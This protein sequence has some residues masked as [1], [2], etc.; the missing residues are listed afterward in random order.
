MARALQCTDFHV[1]EWLS[2]AARPLP[3]RFAEILMNCQPQT[4]SSRRVPVSIRQTLRLLFVLGLTLLSPIVLAQES[5]EDQVVQ[6][7]AGT[8]TPAIGVLVIRDGKIADQAVHGVRRNDQPEAA[9]AD[10]VWLLGSTSKV[11]TVALI[12]RLVEQG[13]LSWETPLQEMLPQLADSMNPAYRDVTLVQLLSHRAGL[14]ENPRDHAFVE[15]FFVDRKPLPAQRLAFVST[16][17]K[18]VPEVTPGTEFVY[19]NSGFVIAGV[20]AERV[21]KS[22]FES[23]MRR[24]VFAPLDMAS[25]GFGSAPAGQPLGHRG[26][27]PVT[28]APKH[29]DDGVPAMYSP[30]G[31]MHMSLHDWALF[32]LDQLAGA[33]GEGK[34]LTSASYRLMQTAQPDSPSG[35]DWSV[36]GSIAGRQGPVLAHGGSDGNTLAWVALFPQTGNGV[37]VVANAAGD[38]GGDQSTHALLGGLLASLSPAQR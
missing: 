2:V 19:S 4:D 14:P 9:G 26:G 35:L 30:A 7:M 37:L 11:M 38:M 32:C 31:N 27:K 8:T 33:R 6:A 25:A 15:S 34:L 20:I 28:S 13:A 10:D 22:S 23:L 1:S 5:L 21:G 36:Q 12:A 29:Y 24:E 3:Q 18:E 17:L 16:A